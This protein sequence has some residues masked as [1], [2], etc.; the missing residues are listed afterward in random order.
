MYE[1]TQTDI[2]SQRVR[3]PVDALRIDSFP[4]QADPAR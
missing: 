4:Q 1:A 3:I 2:D